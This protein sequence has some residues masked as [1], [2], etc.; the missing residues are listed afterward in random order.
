MMPP[1]KVA[2]KAP[3]RKVVPRV[4]TPPKVVQAPTTASN[5]GKSIA[6]AR[7]FGLNSPE[8]SKAALA[9]VK[10]VGTF[11]GNEFLGVDDFKNVKKHAQSGN[12]GRAALSGLT[13]I[14]E[15]GLTALAF[16]PGVGTAASFGIKG[17]VKAIAK[18]P[19]TQ[20]AA[21]KAAQSVKGLAA[22]AKGFAKTP[23]IKNTTN[24]IKTQTSNAIN[25]IK[26]VAIP[27]SLGR[28]QALNAA[29][30]GSKLPPKTP[31][32]GPKTTKPRFYAGMGLAGSKLN[33][34]KK[35][36][37]PA[38]LGILAIPGQRN[39]PKLPDI[40]WGNW[41]DNS[42]IGNRTNNPSE[43]T[44]VT[45]RDEVFDPTNDEKT[46]SDEPLDTEEDLLRLTDLISDS[47]DNSSKDVIDA[48]LNKIIET[49]ELD[50]N[51][52]ISGLT[53]LEVDSMPVT[54]TIVDFNNY[55]NVPKANGSIFANQL[56]DSGFGLYTQ[57][58][59]QSQLSIN[60]KFGSSTE[61]GFIQN[62]VK[63]DVS[64]LPKFDLL[65][66]LPDGRG[67]DKYE[68]QYIVENIT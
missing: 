20:Y 24:T 50:A 37:R 54:S 59:S 35:L 7:S 68:V 6:S 28:A 61:N 60:S 38:T 9:N 1:R 17:A 13:G 51:N 27:A 65:L 25:A 5:P 11:I 14:G 64:G 31:L 40:R 36:R 26:G 16:I 57:V 10:K 41:W 4:T 44:E 63:T 29:R 21:M 47:I 66:T 42:S 48:F 53:L 49:L 58:L 46:W 67:I 43:P 3:P 30:T 12:Y 18:S 19:Q 8:K 52:L 33:K 39:K 15:I 34:L 45:T 2:P 56:P 22:T 23:V 32:R 62:K 55:Y